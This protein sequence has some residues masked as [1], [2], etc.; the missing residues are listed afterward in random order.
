MLFQLS[1]VRRFLTSHNLKN[2]HK[3]K[4]CQLEAEEDVA[5][6]VKD[7]MGI[8]FGKAAVMVVIELVDSHQF[9]V[10]ERNGGNSTCHLI[11]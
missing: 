4:K 2:Q 8:Q 6:K 9:L 10:V 11:P 7:I 5:P 1:F 3:Q